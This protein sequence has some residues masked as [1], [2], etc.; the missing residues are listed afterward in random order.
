MNEAF[1]RNLGRYADLI[2]EVGLNLQK[3][4]ELMIS[5]PITSYEFVR[6]ITEKAYEAGALNVLT[7]FYDDELKKIRLEKSAEEGLK[8]FPEWK[9]KGY[10]EMAENNVALLNLAAPNPSLLRDSDPT[11]VAMLNKT[12]AEAMKDFSAYIGGGKI[13]WLIAAIPTVEWAQTVFPDLSQEEAFTKLWE[14]IFYTTRTDQENTV[15]LWEAHIENLNKNADRLNKGKYKKLH[16]K[17]PGTDLT[18]EFHPK[19]KW[20]SAQFTN[21]KEIPFVPNLPTEEVFSI[22]DKYGVNG[23]VSSTKPLNYSGTLIKNFSLTFKEGKVI[24]YTAEEGYE[25][26]KNLLETDEGASYLGEV[27]LVPHD[28]PISN[29]NIVFNNT[30]FDENA[31]CHIALGRALSVCVEDGKT[32]TREQ[33]QEIGFNESMI[34]VDFMIGSSQ[35]DID[36]EKADGTIEPIFKAGDWV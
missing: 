30:L 5:A 33:L 29:T 17:G 12:S 18:I 27:A 23:V 28:S 26:L 4:Q 6:L 16:Y 32:M 20:I 7:D 35:L 2:V 19:T 21:D 22:P 15:E 1:E 10:I 13:S 9:A 24:D 3:G 8:A 36:G 11:R 14:N 25:T 31:S 34:H